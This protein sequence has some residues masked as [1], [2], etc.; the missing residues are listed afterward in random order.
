MRNFLDRN[1]RENQNTRFMFTPPPPGS[2]IVYRIVW[3]NVAEPGR[4]QIT[5]YYGACV[6]HAG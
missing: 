4:P 3:K 6:L 1:D 2:R 5:M